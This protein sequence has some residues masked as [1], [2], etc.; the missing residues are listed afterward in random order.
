[1]P[2]YRKFLIVLSLALAA[3]NGGAE[4]DPPGEAP[5]AGAK[6]GGA[7]TLTD[8]DGNTVRWSDF[9]GK[10]R[11]VYFGYA[12][13]P[14]VCPLDVQSMMKG[15]RTFAKEQPEL[16]AK[17]QPIFITIDPQRDTPEVIGEFTGAFSEKLLGLTGTPEQV[18]QA[19]KAFA[20]YYAKGETSPGGGYLMDHTRGAYLMGPDGKPIA[21][22]PVDKGADA[23]AAELRKWTA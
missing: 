5:L 6:I 21:L 17:I 9:S 19:A 1:M 3:C 18:E 20:V 23:V 8:K 13:C 15:Y 14:D 7:F 22:L 10:Y 2:H 11:I 16:A 12:Y 4:P